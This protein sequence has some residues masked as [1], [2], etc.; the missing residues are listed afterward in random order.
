MQFSLYTNVEQATIEFC[1]DYNS[2]E[3]KHLL[4]TGIAEHWRILLSK[5]EGS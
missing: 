1:T 4:V 3:M 2:C 5:G